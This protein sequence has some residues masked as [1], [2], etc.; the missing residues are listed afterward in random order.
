MMNLFEQAIAKNELLDF[1]LGKHEYFVV[2]RDY[3]E[4]SVIGS[5]INFIL[6]LIEIKG[7]D[8]INEVIELMFKK[9]IESNKI[10]DQEKNENL[11][12]HLHTYYYLDSE[13]RFKALMPKYL[14]D[15]LENMLT[16]YLSKLKESNDAKYNAFANAIDV[17]K[18]R[19][20]LTKKLI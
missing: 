17:I 3:G 19:G 12:Y 11:L 2:D 14:S 18:F 13:N 15:L 7:T 20:G 1:A 4:H 5:W 6:P 9:I 8:Y 16:L 10:T